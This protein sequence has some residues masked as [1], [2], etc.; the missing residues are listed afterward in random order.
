MGC[1]GNNDD[2]C[3]WVNGEWCQHL[4]EWTVPGRRWACAL[5]REHQDWDLVHADPRYLASPVKA[6]LDEHFPG[7]DCGDW[8][9]K[10]NVTGRCCYG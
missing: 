1:H 10:V 8:P 7:F 2:H 4:E 9:D 5:Y 3:C 6:W